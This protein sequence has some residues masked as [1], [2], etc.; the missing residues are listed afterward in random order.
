[1]RI[2]LF[3]LS[4]SCVL[5]NVA[6][7]FGESVKVMTHQWEQ[8]AK[9]STSKPEVKKTGKTWK[10]PA[11]PAKIEGLTPAE[12][13]ELTKLIIKRE[14]VAEKGSKGKG[15]HGDWTLSD[16]SR[17]R[18]L[19]KKKYGWDPTDVDWGVAR[20]KLRKTGRIDDKGAFKKSAHAAP[21]KRLDI[22]APK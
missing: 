5:W 18:V 12:E 10:R 20:K 14:G 7:V 8:K 15:A 11:P 4:T 16:Q 13:K 2:F 1:M 17:M 6:S 3:A 9:A 21:P 19:V 22:H